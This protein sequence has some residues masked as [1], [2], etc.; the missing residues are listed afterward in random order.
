MASKM[1]VTFD[2]SIEN[3]INVEEDNGESLPSTENLD[4]DEISLYPTR[5]GLGSGPDDEDDD[6]GL[7]KRKR[8]QTSTYAGSGLKDESGG[9][10]KR[11]KLI[12]DEGPVFYI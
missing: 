9:H 2:S 5:P 11:I 7:E 12:F 6:V 1:S 10:I 4:G 3:C 8:T